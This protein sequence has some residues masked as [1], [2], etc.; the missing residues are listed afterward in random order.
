MKAVRIS[1]LTFL[2]IGLFHQWAFAKIY[3]WVDEQGIVHFTDYPPKKGVDSTTIKVQP[4]QGSV[5][6][7]YDSSQV[8]KIIG[9]KLTSLSRTQSRYEEADVE[10]YVTNWCKWCKKAKQFLRSKGISYREYNIETD[11]KAARRKNQ[12][13]PH[14][15]V[16]LAVING[17]LVEGF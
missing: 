8:D 6:S 11:R 14:S 4:T 10:I 5:S 2:I 1:L 16:P 13:S 9:E 12:L 7:Q 17:K 15:G 3:K